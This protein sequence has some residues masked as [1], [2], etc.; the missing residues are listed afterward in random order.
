MLILDVLD[1]T[2]KTRSLLITELICYLKIY[3]QVSVLWIA[4]FN[5]REDLEKGQNCSFNY[6]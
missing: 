1:D 4:N 2:L 6:F 3:L 5:D